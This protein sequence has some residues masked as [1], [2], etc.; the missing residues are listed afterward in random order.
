M[1]NPEDSE[2][3][4]SF[5]R[6]DM[7]E[8]PNGIPAYCEN[9][10]T[11]VN[12]EGLD[13]QVG[14]S[15]PVLQLHMPIADWNDLYRAV[16]L[17]LRHIARERRAEPSESTATETLQRVRASLLECVEALQL[18]HPTHCQDVETSPQLELEI[19][20]NHLLNRKGID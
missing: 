10:N 17:R 1:T 15:P 4:P 9:V 13:T 8:A 11:H 7:G 5:P 19:K 18:L 6:F 3:V 16:T 14:K 20:F 12:D 2:S